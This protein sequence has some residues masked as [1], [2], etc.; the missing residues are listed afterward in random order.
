MCSSYLPWY[1]CVTLAVVCLLCL[2]TLCP[3]CCHV[4]PIVSHTVIADNG[5]VGGNSEKE[6]EDMEEDI[7]MI[8]ES[9]SVPFLEDVSLDSLL[10]SS[11]DHHHH[12]VPPGFHHQRR[13]N[14]STPPQV[15]A[16]AEGRFV[17]PHCDR[18]LKTPQ[19][20]RM[21]VRD[22]HMQ[23]GLQFECKICHRIYKSKNTLS[24]HMSLYHKGIKVLENMDIL[25]NC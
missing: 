13:T 7:Q 24:N 15:S 6:E 10:L 22:Q 3:N 14:L 23:K 19:G 21:H 4:L 25:R 1:T 20:L 5:N 2:A 9:S 8:H 16:T 12:F 18:S 17:C 11:R